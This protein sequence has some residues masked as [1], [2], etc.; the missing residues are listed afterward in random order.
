MTPRGK[1]IF[2]GWWLLAA[3]MLIGLFSGGA[4]IYG[5]TVFIKPVVA[6][7]SWTYEGISLSFYVTGLLGAILIP[8]LGGLVDRF[9]S[10]PILIITGLV[11][12]AGFF[13]LSFA[14]SI[15][16]FYIAF[17]VITIGASAIGSVTI[18]PLLGNWFQKRMA[19]AMGIYLSGVGLGALLVGPLNWLVLTFNW[20]SAAMVIGIATVL[21]IP[22]LALLLR[23]TPE[24]YGW[25]PDGAAPEP[26]PAISSAAEPLVTVAA[27]PPGMTGR[28]AL[29]S[30]TFWLL[31][32][33]GSASFLAYNAEVMHIMP[34]LASLDIAPAQA[35]LVATFM[36]VLSVVGRL[37]FGWLGDIIPRRDVYLITMF[38]QAVGMGLLLLAP[39]GWAL[40]LF[41]VV[42]GVGIGG[43][44]V[45]VPAIMRERFGRGSFGLIQGCML[46]ATSVVGGAGPVLAGR[47][48]DTSG[49]FTWAWACFG[50][51]NLVGLVCLLF[52]PRRAV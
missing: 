19:L 46:A 15:T 32:L 39:A 17:A 31:A 5:I 48:F 2:Y 13:I 12:G 45:M 28:Q 24:K 3:S 26:A 36:P 29:R 51:V 22:G 52:I 25:L 16:V 9:G 49:S 21:V 23:Q 50:A 7:L 11:T 37:G 1:R 18:Q 33:T 47:I 8:L 27:P 4:F 20:H 30:A 34:Y 44:V 41:S 40:G 35:A 14:Y 38:M 10:R 43:A 42:Y 6:D